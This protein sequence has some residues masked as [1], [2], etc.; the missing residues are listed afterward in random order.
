VLSTSH[1]DN[2]QQQSADSKHDTHTHT[3]TCTPILFTNNISIKSMNWVPQ[4]AAQWTSKILRHSTITHPKQVFTHIH[5]PL[6][7][8]QYV[9]VSANGGDTLKMGR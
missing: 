9:L 1:T 8:K 4:Q 2:E 6:F 5:V 3:H 7:T